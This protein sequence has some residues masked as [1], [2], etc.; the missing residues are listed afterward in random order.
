MNL[1]KLAEETG[2]EIHVIHFP[3]GALKWNKAE[4]RLFSYITLNWQGKPLADVQCVINLIGLTGTKP[5]LSVLCQPDWNKYAADLIVSDEELSMIDI[6]YTG[7]H[8]GWSYI[9]RGLKH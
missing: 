5:G 2:I 8:I 6:Q 4:H 9:I 3:P 1:A 7:P